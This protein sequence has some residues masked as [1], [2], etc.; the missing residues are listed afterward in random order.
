MLYLK[1]LNLL[2][3]IKDKLVFAVYTLQPARRLNWRD[4]V[5]TTET[6]EMELEDDDLI[7][8]SISSKGKKVIFNNY[9]T[10]IKYGQQ[11]FK[12]T[13]PEL[14]KI[15]DTYINIRKLKAGNYLFSLE[16]DKKRPIA[17]QFS[18]KKWSKYFIKHLKDLSVLDFCVWVGL[19]H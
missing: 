6:E 19:V 12:L 13:D 1:N 4:V 11:V 5:L 3:N 9:K 16:T 14:S 10:E 2:E 8:W 7:F 15:T 17:N 18:V